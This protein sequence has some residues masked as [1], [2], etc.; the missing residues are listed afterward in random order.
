MMQFRASSPRGLGQLLA[1]ELAAF[2]ATEIHEHS[3]NVSFCGSLE[4]AYRACLWSRTANRV[5]LELAKFEAHDAEAFYTRAREIDWFAHIGPDATLACDF[6][7]QHPALVHT[8]FAALKLKDAICDE[9]RARGGYRPSIS[10]ERPGVRVHAHAHGNAITIAL[11]FSGESLHR[12]GYRREA[13]EAPLKE[14]LAAGILLRSGWPQLAAEGAEFLD[15][16]C[17]SGTFVIEAAMIAADIA[18]G[19][20]REY[21]GFLGWRSHDQ[22]LWLRLKSEAVSRACG[23]EAARATIRGLDN[24]VMAVNRAHGN[25]QNA[26]VVGLVEFAH[27]D[28]PRAAPLQSARSNPAGLLCTNPPYGIRLNDR[29]T[30]RDTY[31]E[32]G[33]MLRE[34]FLGWQAAVLCADP[35]AGLELGIRAHR[36][37]VLWNGA[38]ECRLLRL[39]IDR[40]SIASAVRRREGLQIDTSLRSSTGAQ[41]FANRL[42]KNIKRLRTWA[43]NARVSCYRVYDADM[44]EYALAIDLYR[45]VP[46]G[47]DWLYVQEY[48]APA[49]VDAR[50]ARRRRGEA[51]SALTDV[52]GV[53]T[54]RIRLRLRRKT[55]RGGQYD[56]IVEQADFHAVEEGGLRFRVNFDRYLDTGLFLDLRLMRARLRELAVDKRF[57]NLFAYTGAA[58]VY[59]AAAPAHASTSIDLSKTYLDWAAQNLALNGLQGS[60]HTLLRADCNQWLAA[61]RQ[62][63]ERFDLIFLAP[64]TFSNSKRMQG[65]LDT[66]RDHA[67]LID[68]CGALLTP[69][70]LLIFSTNA[71]RFKLEEGLQNRFSVTDISAQTLP[72]DFERNPRIHRC[73]EL[74]PI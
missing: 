40:S 39:N 44:P 30:S 35:Q 24:D 65:I 72:A 69:G 4:A 17:G 20:K 73:F 43:D 9:L 54:E 15:P 11:D 36:T 34:R 37:H 50:A 28:L 21:F 58:T 2:D 33:T 18:P 31:R 12:R 48:A 61:A 49:T 60:R 26:G 47:L 68:A 46:D 42:A 52:C 56:T 70:G 19:L 64:P 55:R 23:R 51:L 74:R 3:T 62:R 53:P 38:V 14:N 27:T 8:H 45:T 32:L 63:R 25:A 57:L 59:A 13:G 16:M 41:M 1:R 6:S 7:G 67:A 10:T 5:F 66:R 71:Q 29:E 22:D